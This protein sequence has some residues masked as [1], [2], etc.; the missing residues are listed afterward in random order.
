MHDPD[1][2]AFVIPRPWPQR[3]QFS[4]TGSRGDGVR[5]RMR[6]SH[7]C[8]PW[9][10]GDPPHKSGA[11]PWW[12]PGS[13]SRFWRMAGRDFYWPPLVTVWHREPGGYDALSVCRDRVH[14][15]HGKRAGEWKLTRGWHWH[16]WHWRFQVHPY[17]AARRR[18]L[19]RCEWCGG[20]SVKGDPVNV[21]NS[22][23]LPKRPW[24][25]GEADLFHNDCHNVH[26]A[27]GLCL[28]TIPGELSHP[29]YGTC[30]ACGLFRP[31][32][33]QPN[34]PDRLLAALGR[35]ERPGP[36]LKARLAEL[37]AE[38]RA[39]EAAQGDA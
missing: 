7:D 15:R 37:W 18:L 39:S 33:Y 17:H 13:Y 29:D 19:T 11:F 23:H 34:E 35:G 31:Y 8:G 32:G 25:Q 22:W 21:G 30:S 4:A 6:L 16:V 14:R 2:V 27:A 38:A 12:K 3:S 36:E 24:W 5:W 9:C 28:C 1:V 10:S 26:R 20:R